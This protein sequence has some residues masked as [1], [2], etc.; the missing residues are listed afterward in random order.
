MLSTVTRRWLLAIP[1]GIVA[2]T[3]M[4]AIGPSDECPANQAI[5]WAQAHRDALPTTVAE[6]SRYGRATQ[7]AVFFR[8]TPQ[9]RTTLMREHLTP[10][11][12]GKVSMATEGRSLVREYYEAA[13]QLFVL[14]RYD[15][16]EVMTR[17]GGLLERA[18]TAFG[19]SLAREIFLTVASNPS[20]VMSR[21]NQAG[22][23][24]G[25]DQALASLAKTVF[26][27]PD[28]NCTI[29]T[30]CPINQGCFS[31]PGANC[32]TNWCWLIYS[33]DGTCDWVT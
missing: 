7:N 31:G 25:L 12:N 20:A 15:L 18:K 28:C 16:R 10:Y 30:P 6:M 19:D 33:C 17:P 24:G 13:P 1:L 27:D 22:M 21:Y 26:D 11:L 5:K 32:K 9:Q 14:D 23:F 8:L 3:G 29:G 2:T 4:A